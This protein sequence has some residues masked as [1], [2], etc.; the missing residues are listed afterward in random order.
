[1][2][3][4]SAV[5]A[6]IL[7]PVYFAQKYTVVEGDRRTK[8]VKEEVALAEAS[9]KIVLSE[10]EWSAAAGMGAAVWCHPAAKSLLETAEAR[11]VSARWID[12]ETG[13]SCKGRFD[14]YKADTFLFDLKTT[15]DASPEAFAKAIWQWGLH[16]QAA[17]YLNAL[18]ALE[19]PAVPYVFI[20]VESNAPYAVA[21]YLLDDIS[22]NAGTLALSDNLKLYKE[23]L[24]T[25]KWPAFGEAIREISLPDW[26]HAKVEK[27]WAETA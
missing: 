5:H 27:T 24:Q 2:K 20:V 22:V 10:A 21:T 25:N 19:L 15:T 11:E 17:M 26:A 9:S 7:E 8:L 18:K 14:G 12:A 16:K 1:M 4:G 6:A 3:R 23:C 13:L